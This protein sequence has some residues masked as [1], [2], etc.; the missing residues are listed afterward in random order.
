LNPFAP[1]V[2]VVPFRQTAWTETAINRRLLAVRQIL[3]AVAARIIPTDHF[4]VPA[5]DPVV[6][7]Q[8]MERA[9]AFYRTVLGLELRFASPY[10]TELAWR[11][12]VIALPDFDPGCP[13]QECAS[14]AQAPSVY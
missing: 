7:V 2:G 6:P 14:R 9:V 1:V 10:W 13:F 5:Q 4:E 11:D 12:A 8:D 3:F